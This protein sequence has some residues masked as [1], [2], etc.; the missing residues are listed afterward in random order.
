M[1]CFERPASALAPGARTVVE[2]DWSVPRALQRVVE[3]EHRDLLVVGSSGD[4]PDG[5]VYA[6]PR[7]RQ[8]LD[9]SPCALAV[10]PRGMRRTDHRLLRIGV[11]FDGSAESDVALKLAGSLA[12]QAGATLLVRE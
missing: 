7:A 3:R 12:E 1:R 5:V 8:L 9:S 4:G 11:G 10:A 6:G 2:T